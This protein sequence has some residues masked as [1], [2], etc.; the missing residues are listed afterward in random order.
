M[1]YQ[2]PSELRANAFI[3]IGADWDEWGKLINQT[4]AETPPP[5]ATRTTPTTETHLIEGIIPSE[6]WAPIEE[7]KTPNEPLGIRDLRTR[8]QDYLRQMACSYEIGAGDNYVV[9]IGTTKVIVHPPESAECT[10]LVIVVAIVAAGVEP[11]VDLMKYL[12]A[13]NAILVFGKFIVT[14][15]KLVLCQHSLL[16]DDGPRGI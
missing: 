2:T 12:N 8:I 13:E 10:S 1:Y 7:K 3:R 14:E 5:T 11:T 6:M 16:G 9:R 15:E 4:K